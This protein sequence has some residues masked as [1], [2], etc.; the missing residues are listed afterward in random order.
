MIAASLSAFALSAFAF[1]SAAAA[2]AASEADFVTSSRLFVTEAN[3]L[4]TESRAFTSFLP[5]S[6]LMSAESISFLNSSLVF[7]IVFTPASDNVAEM[8]FHVRADF[9]APE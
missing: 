5:A 6:V 4:S 8:L 1:S 2:A 9:S 7:G 3:S